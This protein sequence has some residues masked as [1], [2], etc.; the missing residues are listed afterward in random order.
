MNT[1]VSADLH[2]GHASIFKFCPN[3]IALGDT[4][5]AHDAA[6]I[7]RW[8]AVVQPIDRVYF[9]GD[10][11]FYK[12]EKVI[13]HILDNLNGTIFFVPGNHD[14]HIMGVLNAHPRVKVQPPLVYQKFTQR[15]AVLCHYPLVE[16][17]NS[18]HGTYMLHG[19]AHG[20]YPESKWRCMDVGIDAHPE[21]RPWSLSEVR[22]KLEERPSQ[23]H[24]LY[25][26]LQ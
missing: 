21:M 14:K 23:D 22:A 9:L 3:R 25:K 18:F 6:L 20:Q 15:S 5:E 16:W 17:Q 2:F 7:E 11:T 10:L 26:E 12:E 13:R 1:F 4:V 19:H 8:N 24:S